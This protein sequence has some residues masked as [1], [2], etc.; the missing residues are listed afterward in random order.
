MK[1]IILVFFLLVFIYPVNAEVIHN[2]YLRDNEFFVNSTLI[3]N[4]EEKLDYWNLEI[5]LP[6]KTEIVGLKDEIG[7]ITY[8]FS[9]NHLKFRTN[10]KRANT[11]I[12][13]LLFRKNLGEEYGFKII[14]LNLFGFENDTTIIISKKFP[15]FFIPGAKVEYGEKIKARKT[16]PASLRIIFGGKKES[17]HYFTNSNLNLSLPEKYYWVPEGIT[18]LKV[19]VKFAIVSLPKEGYNL[20]LEK[21]SGGTYNSGIIFIREEEDIKDKVATIMHETTHGINSFALNWDRTNISWFDE[22]VACYVTS[23]IYRMLNETRPQIFGGD[24]KWRNGTVIY[25]LKPNQKPEDLFNYYNKGENW[26]SNWYPSK[27]REN[28]KREFGYAYSELF[29]REYLKENGSGLH[30][31][32]QKLLKINK[33]VENENE[34]NEIILHIF[35]KE[36]KPCY[37]L[38]LEE[39]KNCT[40]ELNEMNFEI[41]QVNGKEIN[42]KVEVPELPEVEEYHPLFVEIE[43]LFNKISGFFSNI[44]SDLFK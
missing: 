37:S 42:Y 13:N 1:K 17:K 34:R 2:L 28:Y 25:T 38:N 43:N 36:F 35:G 11:R 22:G 6:E 33:S 15:Y 24:I 21:W 29:I 5:I 19:P 27:Y 18:G 12:V 26:V 9:E 14:D 32:Y 41:P 8:D 23:V 44:I 30:K 31:V 3:L 7:N 20:K 16:G 40:K 10:R 4:S 39:I